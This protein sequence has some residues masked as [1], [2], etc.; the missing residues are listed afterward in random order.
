MWEKC[1][2]DKATDKHCNY[3]SA[4]LSGRLN[5]LKTVYVPAYYLG[6]FRKDT[7]F[8]EH[9]GNEFI[10]LYCNFLS[11]CGRLTQTDLIFFLK[12][13]TTF[14]SILQN[15]LER[16]LSRAHYDLKEII[17]LLIKSE[18]KSVYLTASFLMKLIKEYAHKKE[19]SIDKIID[20]LKLM[21]E[22]QDLPL[23]DQVL[24]LAAQAQLFERKQLSK[25]RKS[26]QI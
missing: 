5:E 14:D 1:A 8:M 22:D 24:Y 17:T 21:R 6:A 16:D 13:V 18:S 12:D 3:L 10:F 9:F 19:L 23:Y 15:L 2:K 4:A 7:Q 26:N 11:K 25:L 20:E